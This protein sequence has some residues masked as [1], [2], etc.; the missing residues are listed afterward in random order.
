MKKQLLV[1]LAVACTL[2]VNAQDNPLW[3]RYCAISPDGK[4]IAFSYKGD[5]YRVPTEGGEARQL[6]SNAAYDAMPVWSPDGQHIAF[7]S[8]REG[9][10]DVYLMGKDGGVPTRLTTHSGDEVP[11]AFSDDTH[12]LFS[13]YLMPTAESIIFPSFSFPQVYSVGTQGGRPHLFSAL[14]MEDIS[15]NAQGDVLYHDKKGYEDPFRK[16]HQSPITRDI[17]LLRKGK[18]TKLTTFAGEDRNAVWGNGDNYYYLSEEDGT[19]N[20]Y[21]RQ[22]GSASGQQLT[23]FKDNPVRFLSR[24]ND[25]TLCFG[26]NGELYTLREGQ[27]PQKVNV[28]VVADRND[29]DLDR[30]TLTRGA[31]EIKLSPSGKE[32]AFVLHGDVYVTSVDYPTTKQ[33]TDTPEQERSIDFSPDGR[34]IVYASERDGLWQIYI[35]K[36]KNKKENN[37]TYA[38]DLE[39]EQLVNSGQTSFQPLFSPDGKSVAY[40]ENRTTLRAVDVKSH[41]LRTLMDGKYMYSYSDGDQWFQ[42][43]PDSRWLLTSYI[44]T[45]GWNN[46]DI[47]LVNA[48]GNGEIHDVTQSGYNDGNAK[49]VLDGKAMIF[50]SDRA[51]YRSHGSWGTESDAYIM[52][53]DLDAYERFR[54]SK[55][56]VALDD[57]QQKDKKKD[58]DDKSKSKKDSLPAPKKMKALKLDLERCRDRVLRLTVNSSRLGDIVLS[59]KGDVL[60]YQAAF[61]GGFDLW[62][63]DLKEG[64]T[65]V[66]MKNVGNGAMMADKDFKSLYLC[67]QGSIKKIDV[68]RGSSKNVAFSARFNYKP[69]QERE[70]MFEHVWKQV[71]DKFYDVNLHGVDWTAYH[72]NYKR[73]LPFINNR[74]DFRDMLSEMLGELNASH[75]GARFYPDGPRLKTANLGLF[76]DEEYDGDGLKVKEVIERGPFDVRNTGVKAGDVIEKIDGKPILRDSDYYPLLDGKAGQRVRISVVS[77]KGKHFDVVVRPIST[78]Q[79]NELLYRRWVDRNRKKVYELSGGKLAYVHVKAMD[80]PSFRTVFSEVLCDSNRQKKALIVDERHNGGGWLHDDLCTLLGGKQYQEFVPRGQFIGYDPWNKWVKPSCVMICEDDYSN[81]HGFPWVYKTLGIGRLIGAPVAG[82]M[83][84]VWWETMIDRQ[85]VFGIPQVGCRGMDGRFGENQQLNPDIEV[86]NTP[87]DYLTGNDRQ[88]EAAVKAMLG[89]Q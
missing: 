78:S 89:Q 49:W 83:T 7:A 55:E 4:S 71:K 61:E 35:T 13:T 84:A 19:F 16:H 1:S 2:V 20:V 21:K 75:T 14:P 27:E 51:G 67:T 40:L 17:W 28:R 45:G 18:Y 37:F 73:F 54:M 38:T 53:F 80:S 56:E 33:I 70:Y 10:L 52:F 22:V 5:I 69:Y 36:I 24:A 76:F 39:E 41:E 88:L 29:I 77:A 74:Y 59:Q 15:V 46:A 87:E 66:V 79:Q 43:S 9:S 81:G 11:M 57:E 44:G 72:D 60:Y 82:T 23:H 48:S 63:H 6:T 64:K 3:M 26:Q 85:M 34:S 8:S 25:G 58:D 50:E 62:K 31:T 12:V 68:G 30:Q 32:I 47:A 42:W 86:Y 65:Q